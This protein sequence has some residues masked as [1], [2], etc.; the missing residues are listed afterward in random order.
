MLPRDRVMAVIENR[1]TDRTPLDF[2]ATPEM[3]DKLKQYF[4]TEHKS[5]VLE[6][7]HI[8]VRD[9]RPQYIGPQMPILEDG[10][11]FEPMGTHRRIVSNEYNSYDEYASFPLAYAKTTED[12]EQHRWFSPDEY[13]YSGFSTLIG[14]AHDIYCTKMMVGGL[15]ELAWAL[16]GY[17]QYM[18]DMALAPEI[19]HYIMQRITDFYCIYIERAMEAAGDKIDII[20]SYDDIACQRGMLISVEM[21][22]EFIKPYHEQMNSV[23]K[24]YGKKILYHTCGNIYQPKVLHGLVEMGIDILN[25]IQMC[26][27]MTLSDLKREY[28][29]KLC[30]HGGMD[31]QKVLPFYTPDEIRA[32]TRRLT[33]ILD[34][35]FILAST[36]YIQ[37]D[38]PVENVI[39]MYEEA[40]GTKI[41]RGDK[42]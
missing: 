6:K 3:W 13:D 29:G 14:D 34:N 36:H 22:R 39:A 24:K 21:W 31:I 41:G 28:G 17:E 11:Y 2:W 35:G 23:A 38:T 5:T 15:F 37:N 40:T 1:E 4:G 9:Y 16:R 33:K 19:P 7:L 8:D 26:G 42:M 12:L 25:P 27:E 20:F 18:M 30:F 10:S 32:E